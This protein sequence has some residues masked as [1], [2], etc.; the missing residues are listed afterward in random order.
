MSGIG[1]ITD[2]LRRGS[3]LVMGSREEIY[4]QFDTAAGRDPVDDCL[5]KLPIHLW[6]VGAVLKDVASCLVGF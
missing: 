3:S 2:V 6:R 1:T 5:L 4:H